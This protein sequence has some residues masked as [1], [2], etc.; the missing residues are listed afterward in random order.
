MPVPIVDVLEVIEVD[1]DGGDGFAATTCEVAKRE[2]RGQE[3][4]AIE[5]SRKGVEMTLSG[6]SPVLSR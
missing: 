4:P 5:D 1:E 3:P 2:R 6:E